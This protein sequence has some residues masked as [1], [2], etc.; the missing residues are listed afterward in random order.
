MNIFLSA[1]ILGITLAMDAFSLSIMIAPNLT[2]LNSVK[3]ISMVGVMHLILPILG[4][5]L[6]S[7]T[8]SV[9]TLNG[10]F[11]L[12]VILI[13]LGVQILLTIK[14]NDTHKIKSSILA[15]CLL[16]ISVSFDSF[17]VGFG[18]SFSSGVVI[19]NSIIF[20]ICSII[21]TTLGLIIGKYISSYI[22]IY[23]KFI[24][25]IV[26]IFYGISQIYN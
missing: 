21:F 4:G 25:A 14:N 23:S 8:S 2:K 11:I 19:I 15:L 20:S 24:S 9:I 7:K 10:N 6:G 3:F 18:L 17:S 12:G 22:G 1:L 5:L 26:L 13:I 16:A